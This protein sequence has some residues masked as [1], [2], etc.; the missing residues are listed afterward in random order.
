VNI[1]DKCK[2]VGCSEE[3]IGLFLIEAW[4]GHWS[5]EMPLCLEH[6]IE[7]DHQGYVVKLLKRNDKNEQKENH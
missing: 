3:A 4:E 7:Y 2:K 6:F 1:L 5:Q